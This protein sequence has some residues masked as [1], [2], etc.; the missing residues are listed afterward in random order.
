[1]VVMLGFGVVSWFDPPD[2]MRLA[3]TVS[4]FGEALAVGGD[5]VVSDNLQAS[6]G[7][8][9]TRDCRFDVSVAELPSALIGGS[10]QATE[11]GNCPRT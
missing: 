11:V 4:A 7:I 9:C 3:D 10:Y 8:R 6:S 2:A 1:M 5:R